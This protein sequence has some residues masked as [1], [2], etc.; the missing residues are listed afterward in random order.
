MLLS[1]WPAAHALAH[2]WTLAQLL[3]CTRA[4]P[5]TALDDANSAR[6]LPR[7]VASWIQGQ[8]RQIPG[9]TASTYPT[10]DEARAAFDSVRCHSGRPF[11][12][13][14][15]TAQDAGARL[16]QDLARSIDGMYLE[17]CFPNYVV[18]SS[19]A[20]S[21]PTWCPNFLDRASG[22]YSDNAGPVIYLVTA[23]IEGVQRS[24]TTWARVEAPTLAEHNYV[25]V[26]YVNSSDFSHV[27]SM[28]LLVP[29][30]ALPLPLHDA[31]DLKR[32]T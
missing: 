30:T 13:Y 22:I 15:E 18:C 23:S 31:N 29:L 1:T 3:Q 27:Q 16:A 25:S 4:A 2:I 12:F 7:Y 26:I 19:S 28:P 5:I 20:K 14:T 24:N 8:I 11:V 17:D 9:P 21:E 32:T 10:D 6:I